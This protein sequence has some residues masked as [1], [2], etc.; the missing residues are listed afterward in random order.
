MWSHLSPPV[1][2]VH[3]TEDLLKDA[4]RLLLIYLRPS[5]QQHASLHNAKVKLIDSKD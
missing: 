4:L 3:G 2:I 5:L 1:A